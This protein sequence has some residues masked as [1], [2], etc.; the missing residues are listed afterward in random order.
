MKQ[1][2]RGIIDWGGG[3]SRE[4]L[5]SNYHKLRDAKVTWLHSTERKIYRYVTDFFHLEQCPPSSKIVVEFFSKIDDIETVERLKDI[6]AAPAYEGANFNQVLR[7]VIEDARRTQFVAALK[8]A[9]EI[10]Q[11]G[12][13]IGE[14][15]EKKRLEGVDEARH[16]LT[17]ELHDLELES[18]GG[19]TEA[20]VPSPEEIR[21]EWMAL[22][23]AKITTPIGV[24]TGLPPLDAV[25]RGL[26]RKQL[27]THAAYTGGLK[28]TWALNW[29]VRAVTN[30]VR[31]VN[32]LFYS[33]EMSIEELRPAACAIH[34]GNLGRDLN[35]TEIR[36]GKLDEAGEDFYRLTLDDLSAGEY[37]HI[38]LRCPP[39]VTRISDIATEAQRLSRDYDID[40]VVIDH[41][42]LIAT[43]RYE[44]DIVE[45][46]SVTFRD[47][48]KF[49]R[50]AFNGKGVGV[51]MLHQI[52][53]EGAK[54]AA[55]GGEFRLSDMSMTAEA[56]RSS[57]VL[58]TSWQDDALRN[59]G[60]ARFQLL[61]NRGQ[62][63][64]APFLVEVHPHS[65]RM[66]YAERSNTVPD[67][68]TVDDILA[69]V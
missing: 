68:R 5:L 49:A 65:R 50:E 47:A 22:Q 60:Q 28:S 61:K 43:D 67:E 10:A 4:G 6:G 44:R 27:W 2:L 62:P 15:R 56:E 33:L 13:V 34:T 51:L 38:L 24:L 36:T 25:T 66:F 30:Q 20:D 63:I 8:S 1:L 42:V 39:R 53:R 14:G 32:V 54:R 59:A 29:A 31:P 19:K 7:T 52:N 23:A 35:L 12:L 69:N 26:Q 48:K 37:G 58:T 46:Y 3:I 16:W 11:R 9:S 55:Q 64:I 17:S 57:D 45:R 40:M 18:Q 21:E 41:S